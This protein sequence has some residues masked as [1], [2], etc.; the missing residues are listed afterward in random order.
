MSRS[1]NAVARKARK[2]KLFKAAKGYYG[3][4]KNC[5]TVARQTVE[6]GRQ[7][8]YRDR[9]VRKRDFRTLWIARINAGV[10]EYGLVYSQFINGLNKAGIVLDRKI[11]AELAVNEPAAFKN[12][13]EQA[14]AALK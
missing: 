13:V 2:K 8:A 9:K 14:K 1:T 4:K 3:R 10:R 11:L 6:K 7:Y 5:I 12:V